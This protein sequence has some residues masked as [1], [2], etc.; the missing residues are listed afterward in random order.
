MPM[1]SFRFRDVYVVS[2]PPGDYLAGIDL[3]IG[4]RV[5]NGRINALTG[6]PSEAV[7][8]LSANNSF[9]GGHTLIGDVVRAEGDVVEIKDAT[10]EDGHTFRFEPLTMPLWKKL[11]DGGFI[12]AP[13]SLAALGDIN[14]IKNV[15]IPGVLEEWWVEDPPDV[16]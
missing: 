10:E 5:V 4:V 14:T 15:L 11:L 9:K 7:E 3:A 12:Q 2:F 13:E 6:K 16:W 8:W 1:P